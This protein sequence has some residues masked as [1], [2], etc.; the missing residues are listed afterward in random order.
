M[1]TARFAVVL[2]EAA[3]EA[4]AEAEVE[5]EDAELPE[6]AEPVVPKGKVF[7]WSPF[8]TDLPVA[9]SKKRLGS[10]AGS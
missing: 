5:A 8:L 10:L 2:E 3:A 4:E 1:A 6:E 9:G 7:G